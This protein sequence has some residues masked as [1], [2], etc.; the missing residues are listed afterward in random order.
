MI[1][2]KA[3]GGDDADLAALAGLGEGGFD[4]CLSCPGSAIGEGCPDNI[5]GG[6]VGVFPLAFLLG[7]AVIIKPTAIHQPAG[8][9]RV[10]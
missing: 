7:G 1:G 8:L 6:L 9:G 5:E 4:I 3:F 10:A 2:V